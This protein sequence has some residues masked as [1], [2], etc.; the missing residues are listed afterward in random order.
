MPRIMAMQATKTVHP[1]AGGTVLIA[2][3]GSAKVHALGYALMLP[4][5]ITSGLLVATG[6]ALNNL[7]AGEARR[8]PTFWW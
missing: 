1:P 2:L 3:M 5:G 7:S 6:V 4:V 8:Y